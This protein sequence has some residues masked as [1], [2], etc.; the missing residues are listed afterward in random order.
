[1]QN[2]FLKI[3]QQQQTHLNTHV[4][5]IALLNSCEARS[6]IYLLFL[7]VFRVL[8]YT[9]YLHLLCRDINFEE[10]LTFFVCLSHAFSIQSILYV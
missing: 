7:F 10:I 9:P 1:M 8:L 3:E 5:T 2:D 4:F 6:M